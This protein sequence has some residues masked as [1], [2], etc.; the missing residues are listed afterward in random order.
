MRDLM[1][2][3]F[4]VA[5]LVVLAACGEDEPAQGA[6]G[7]TPPSLPA[8]VEAMWAETD[9]VVPVG[10][11]ATPWLPA[12]DDGQ[13]VAARAAEEDPWVL[14][15]D[16]SS[17]AQTLYLDPTAADPATGRALLVGR[18]DLS[19]TEGVLFVP[20]GEAVD[21]AGI[22]GELTEVGDLVVVSWPRSP[23]PEECPDC[24]QDLFVAGRGIDRDAVV[25][26]ARAADPLADLPSLPPEAVDGLRA[27]GTSPAVLSRDL[28]GRSV[29]QTLEL[30]REGV[31]LVVAVVGSDP[32]LL[33]HLR[34]WAPGGV[35]VTRHPRPVAAALLDDGT[36]AVA[37]G[38]LGSRPAQGSREAAVP[39]AEA[40]LASLAPATT[41]D[42]AAAQQA[43]LTDVPLEPCDAGPGD[44]VDI[45]GVA[46]DTRWSVGIAYADGL[47]ATCST[48]LGLEGASGPTG[49]AA[50][51]HEL[52]LDAPAEVVGLTTGGDGAGGWHRT[53]VGH[54]R[55]E[56][57]TVE[58]AFPGAAPVAA[59]LADTGPTPDRRWFAV[60]LNTPAGNV[61]AEAILVAR[62]ASGAEIS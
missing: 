32:R 50:G 58:V 13:L 26:A 55:A 43:V 30:R 54:V 57:A 41:E 15:P 27:L 47:L 2:T 22:G 49:L 51:H 38:Q 46:E 16:P 34:F 20:A 18:V 1:K 40:A 44:Q 14:P 52:D 60:V 35:E 53:V 21:I 39:V 61:D 12:D 11:P 56:A 42:V 36:V 45:I 28:A 7:P 59:V 37:T 4:V 48:S 8:E 29:A 62:D 5:A 24:A 3:A 33:A 31:D 9:P 17:A 23:M 19:D 10:P 25:A 6:D